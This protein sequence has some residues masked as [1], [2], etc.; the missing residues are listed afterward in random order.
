MSRFGAI[1]SPFVANELGRAW[2]PAPALVFSAATLVAA[3]CILR[4]PEASHVDLPDSLD[5]AAHVQQ[6]VDKNATA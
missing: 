5:E 1:A 6:Q 4:L 3:C 2:L